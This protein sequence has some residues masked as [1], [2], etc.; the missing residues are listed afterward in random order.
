MEGIDR[1]KLENFLTGKREEERKLILQ[2]LMDSKYIAEAF[3]DP[4]G[5]AIFRYLRDSYV[6]NR[7][8]ILDVSSNSTLSP[9]VRAKQIEE[10]G[11]MARIIKGHLDYLAAMW[12]A[13]ENLAD[14]I[15]QS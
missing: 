5:I 8:A 13:G 10:C 9:E 15:N 14:T 12:S 3:A 4:R 7:L 2:E 6:N 11:T 1:F